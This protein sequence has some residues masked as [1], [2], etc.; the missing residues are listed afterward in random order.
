M[1][2][3]SKWPQ[4]WPVG[5]SSLGNEI[6]GRERMRRD[7]RSDFSLSKILNLIPRRVFPSNLA[8]FCLF[9]LETV[10]RPPW[11]NIRT[12]LAVVYYWSSPNQAATQRH[13]KSRP[14]CE[15]KRKRKQRGQRSR[16]G[17]IDHLYVINQIVMHGLF[18]LLSP[19][20]L[21][22]THRH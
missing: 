2:A 12:S 7:A 17:M 10:Y 13:A 4:L 16:S 22:C 18:P 6:L 3:I 1:I 21:Q 9:H 19:S 14:S 15:E 20:A 11:A 8:C 5:I